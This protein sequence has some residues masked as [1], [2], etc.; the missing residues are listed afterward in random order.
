MLEVVCIGQ[1]S[2]LFQICDGELYGIVEI[3]EQR[4]TSPWRDLAL[5]SHPAVAAYLGDWLSRH[6]ILAGSPHPPRLRWPS[7][8]DRSSA[9]RWI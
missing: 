6:G 2:S 4:R 1:D 3:D 5:L 8:E 9:S 7:A